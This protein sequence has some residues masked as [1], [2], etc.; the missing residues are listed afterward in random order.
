MK[1]NHPTINSCAGQQELHK[2]FEKKQKEYEKKMDKFE[3]EHEKL[4]DKE[5]NNKH[6][7]RD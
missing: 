2:D 7:K 1:L 6:G 4:Q 3:R 5:H